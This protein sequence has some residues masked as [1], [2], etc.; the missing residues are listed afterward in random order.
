VTTARGQEAGGRIQGTGARAVLVI[1]VLAVAFAAA[2]WMVEWWIVPLLAAV[3][4]VGMGG[5][6]TPGR[7]AVGAGLGWAGLLALGAMRAPVAKLAAMLGALLHTP[8]VVLVLLTV[9][10]PAV[11]AWSAAAVVARG[12]LRETTGELPATE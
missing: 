12:D 11:L 7:I 9:L 6:A 3:L 8:P 5:V 4:S 2:S 1:L 10:F